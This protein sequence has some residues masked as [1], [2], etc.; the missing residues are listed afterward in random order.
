VL[1][2]GG[3]DLRMELQHVDQ[4][5]SGE[6]RLAKA[7][8]MPCRWLLLTV[9][10]KYKE[11]YHIAAQ[12]TLNTCYRECIQLMVEHELRTVAIPCTFYHKGYPQEDQAHVA[13]RTLR[14]CIEKMQ[15]SLDTVVIAAANSQEVELYDSLMP[16]Y[17]PR[18]TYEAEAGARVLPDCC[19]SEWGEVAVEERKIRLSTYLVSNRDDDDDLGG[20]DRQPVFSPS[21]DA[22]RTFLEA[23]DDAD[24]VA[25]K[26]LEGTMIEAETPE[27]A[28]HICIRY[29]RLARQITADTLATRFVFSVGEDR[30]GRHVV[31]LLGARLP[32]LG[33]RD[34]KTL[35]LFVKVLEALGGQRFV[36]LY[37][38]S[39][40]ATFDTT[41]LEV[42]QEM[43]AV[44]SAKYRNSL[45]QLLVLHPGIWFRAAFA[46]GRAVSDLTA[47][48]WN[49]TVYIEGLEE[50]SRYISIQQLQLPN[51]VTFY[52]QGHHG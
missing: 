24:D 5:R 45:E 19:W 46:L 49:E 29:L 41:K 33:V 39:D 4:C 30:F 35:P 26:R 50:L 38:N 40:V 12:N 7:Y 21:D 10:P 44:I 3:K 9:G 15:N 23:K 34:D 8:N 37:V 48:V 1:R 2:H 32:A 43:L 42:L 22:D 52:E 11:K 47:S 28:R 31:V 6:A 25:R 20:W 14:R 13:L 16:F 27:M 18:N 17:F 51:Y 36:L